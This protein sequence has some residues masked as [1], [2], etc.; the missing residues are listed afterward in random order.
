MQVVIKVMI[1]RNFINEV[2]FHDLNLSAYSDYGR[3]FIKEIFPS[4]RSYWQV[5]ST[6]EV[7]FNICC[8]NKTPVEVEEQL[9]K[10]LE[11]FQV[12]YKI[13]FTGGHLVEQENGKLRYL[14]PHQDSFPLLDEAFS[15]NCTQDLDRFFELV[16]D[17]K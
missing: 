2:S 4:I 11:K 5:K 1:H 6:E 15:V 8:L 9:K 16:E 12:F 10:F 17:R 14:M 3:R 13:Q 7:I